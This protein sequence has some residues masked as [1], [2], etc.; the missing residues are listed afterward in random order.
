MA[1]RYYRNMFKWE[2][3]EPFCLNKNFWDPEDL[4]LLDEKDEMEAPFSEDEIRD[5]VYSCYA[6]G[7][8]GPDGLSFLFYHKFWDIV[9]GDIMN[10]FRDFYE[11]G[12][13][14]FRLN[15]AMLTLIPKVEDAIDMKMFSPISLLNCCFKNF[16]KVL[17]IRLEKVSHRLVAKEQSA[18]IKGRFI[19][20]SV[21]IAHE[22]IHF[23]HKS[24]ELGVVIKLDYKKPMIKLTLIFSWRF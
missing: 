12:I 18:F 11:G 20:E 16:S 21:V 24:K 3:R 17:T 10:M 19:L 13:D 2:S 14:L 15:F 8:P 23:L 1:V 9:K 7:A 5:V 4:V 22:V 6:E